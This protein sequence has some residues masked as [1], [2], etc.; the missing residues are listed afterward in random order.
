MAAMRFQRC[1]FALAVLGCFALPWSAAEE[2]KEQPK[3]T[4]EIKLLF[5]LTNAARAKEKLPALTYNAVL[6]RMAV[7]HSRNMAKQ[8]SM[9]HELDSKGPNA[10]LDDLNYEWTE[11]SENIAA[12]RSLDET[13]LIFEL[14]MKSKYHR[15]NI[16]GKDYEEMGI[17]IEQHQGKGDWYITQVFGA[18]RKK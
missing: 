2:K 12:P 10:R 15:D 7:E 6:T 1:L 9:K 5:D 11:C 17:G 14:W 18:Q 8:K 13:K 3:L 4:K 16:L